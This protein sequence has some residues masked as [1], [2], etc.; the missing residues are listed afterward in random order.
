MQGKKPDDEEPDH[1]NLNQ[2]NELLMG[3]MYDAYGDKADDI[4]DN[5]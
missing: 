4:V 3:K 2:M 5:F 1:M